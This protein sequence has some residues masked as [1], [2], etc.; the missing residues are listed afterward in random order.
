[1]DGIIITDWTEEVKV[2]PKSSPFPLTSRQKTILLKQK[3]GK[4][5][6]FYSWG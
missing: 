5:G 1:M 4:S 6:F 2:V 3:P